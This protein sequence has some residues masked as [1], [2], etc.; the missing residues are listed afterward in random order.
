MDHETHISLAYKLLQACNADQSAAVYSLLPVI[1]REPAHYHRVYGHILRNQPQ[2]IDAALEILGGNS[3][4]VNRSSY[5]YRRIVEDKEYFK[6]L[7][8]GAAKII[9]NES[10]KTPS[11]DKLSA[12]I[13]IISH[14]YFDTFNNPVQAFLPES[15]YCSAQWKFWEDIDYLKFRG[16]FYSDSIIARFRKK[17]LSD[18]IWEVKLDPQLFRKDAR[19]RLLAS[20]ELEKKLDPYALVKAMIIRLGELAAPE[21]DYDII[22]WSIREFLSYLGSDK[23]FRP[24]RELVFCKELEKRIGSLIVECLAK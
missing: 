4:Q 21:I 3:S 17:V 6:K 22:D 10:I 18:P 24:D 2:I 15:A 12:T 20:K 11:R 13:A 1:D 8:D 5:E 14:I 16:E 9:A 23:Y 7:I 19:E